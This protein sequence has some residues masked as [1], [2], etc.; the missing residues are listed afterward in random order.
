[1]AK[2]QHCSIQN[3]KYRVDTVQQLLRDHYQDNEITVEV[4]GKYLVFYLEP[5]QQYTADVE[6]KIIAT[7]NRRG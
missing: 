2:T 6:K 5:G 4:S 3:Y 1:M 7:R